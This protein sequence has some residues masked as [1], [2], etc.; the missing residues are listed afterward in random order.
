[1]HNTHTLNLHFTRVFL[2]SSVY[3][4]EC[5][6]QGYHSAHR[7][8]GL[9]YVLEKNNVWLIWMYITGINIGGVGER[10]KGNYQCHLVASLSDVLSDLPMV[11]PCV[12]EL[13]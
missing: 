13:I 5:E 7:I 4:W 2:E 11:W 9:M 6:G 8:N 3:Y 12:K 10:N 1:M